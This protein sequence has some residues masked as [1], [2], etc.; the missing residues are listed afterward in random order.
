MKGQSVIKTAGLII[1]MAAVI[2]TVSVGAGIGLLQTHEKAQGNIKA[3]E[4]E[5][6]E[7][8]IS[9]KKE[10]QD[11]ETVI[12]EYETTAEKDEDRDTNL[13]LAC[14]KINDA[15][16]LP[17]ETFSFIDTVGECTQEAGF[18]KAPVI[19]NQT[20]IEDDIGGGICQVSS[21]LYNAALLGDL[22]IIESS[23]HSIALQYVPVGLDAVISAPDKDLKIQ[24]TYSIPIRIEAAS[25]DGRVTVK[26]Y[27]KADKEDREIKVES[28]VTE[29]LTP[30]GEEVRLTGELPQGERKVVQEERTGYR[31]KVYREYYEDGVLV[32]KE[33]ISEDT[34]L[35]VKRIVLE[36]SSNI[37]K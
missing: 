16:I 6:K 22:K 19:I 34:Y 1:L 11:K 36:G 3:A 37:T 27:G 29:E 5:R 10:T 23:R 24:N 7:D 30:D 31:T 2:I 18:V 20:Q 32:D 13:R 25:Q 17:G 15:E 33:L 21:T 14:S 35:P 26:L 12:G 8:K 28:L 9:A 4:N